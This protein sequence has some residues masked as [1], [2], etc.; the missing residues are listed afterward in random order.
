MV[1]RA[2][3]VRLSLGVR[4]EHGLSAYRS[5]TEH[6]L[7]ESSSTEHGLSAYRFEGTEHGLSAYRFTEHGL[8]AYRLS[9]YTEH[10]LS[11]YRSHTEHCLSESS[12]GI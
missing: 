3:S 2:W 12:R 8:S 7:S 5:H 9:A 6:C 11:A 1:H 10:G 4:T